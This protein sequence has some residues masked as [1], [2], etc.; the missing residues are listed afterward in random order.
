[1]VTPSNPFTAGADGNWSVTI[2][3]PDSSV[4]A[5]LSFSGASGATVV[6]AS[7]ELERAGGLATRVIDVIAGQ[8]HEAS[9]S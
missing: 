3:A 5:N 6:L 9:A 4:G 7:H 1:V 8:A 2:A